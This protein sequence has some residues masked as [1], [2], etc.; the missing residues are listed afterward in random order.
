MDP[1]PPPLSLRG[2]AERGAGRAVALGP[3]ASNT[4]HGGRLLAC[5]GCAR[6]ITSD[7]ARIEVEGRHEHTFANPF[8]YAYHIGCFAAASGLACVGLPS[9]EF[10]WFSGHT[11]QVEQC[12]G[13]GE[14]LGWIFRGPASGFHGLILERLIEVV[15]ETP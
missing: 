9:G 10:A 2:E 12:G 1:L 7:A 14:H 4:R 15:E 5:A 8:G 13:C 11:W 3:E 6:R